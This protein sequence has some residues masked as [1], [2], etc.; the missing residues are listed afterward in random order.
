MCTGAAP[1]N[2]RERDLKAKEKNQEDQT[3]GNKRGPTN[4]EKQRGRSLAKGVVI[5]FLGSLSPG[6]LTS[7]CEWTLVTVIRIANVRMTINA[8]TMTII[9]SI[10]F[11]KI[12]ICT[13]CMTIVRESKLDGDVEGF[14]GITTV[15]VCGSKWASKMAIPK[16][17]FKARP[18]RRKLCAF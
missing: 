13:D 18:N 8:R 1:C 12:E 10:V 11:S 2:C 14:E 7:L 4:C 15:K 9:D 3:R 5:A 6:C 16:G 17:L